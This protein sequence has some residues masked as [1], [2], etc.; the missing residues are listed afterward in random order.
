MRPWCSLSSIPWVFIWRE[1]Q[2]LPWGQVKHVL[3]ASTIGV[4]VGLWLQVWL[5]PNAAVWL[6]LLLAVVVILA[7]ANPVLAGVFG[8]KPPRRG[9]WRSSVRSRVFWVC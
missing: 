4:M 8:P 9:P 1:R 3:W 5:S 6:R 2:P 7:A